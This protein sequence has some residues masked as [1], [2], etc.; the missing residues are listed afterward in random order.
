MNK[1]YLI[2]GSNIDDRLLNL[3]RAEELIAQQIG[4]PIRTSH[5]F[6][7]ESW[8]YESVNSFYNQ[9]FF[10]ESEMKAEIILKEILGIE[11]IMGRERHDGSYAD[12]IIDID[13]LFF[14]DEVISTEKLTIPHPR[15]HERRFALAPLSEIAGDFIHPVFMKSIGQL[16]RECDDKLKVNKL[17]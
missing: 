10:L 4:N 8:G 13:I 12:R 3:V 16:L 11:K 1:V 2:S 17:D 15:L 7:T 5:I 6:D 9:C 14:N